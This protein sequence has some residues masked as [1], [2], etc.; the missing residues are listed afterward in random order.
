MRVSAR[1]IGACERLESVTEARHYVVICQTYPFVNSYRIGVLSG[2][3]C[4]PAVGGKKTKTGA[5]WRLI[6]SNVSIYTAQIAQCQH[7]A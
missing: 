5:V 3:A 2:D 7:T 1:P 6:C 4:G